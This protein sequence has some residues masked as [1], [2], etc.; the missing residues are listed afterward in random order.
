MSKTDTLNKKKKNNIV[1]KANKKDNKKDNKKKDLPQEAD[2]P[3]SKK[4]VNWVVLLLFALF[5]FISSVIVFGGIWVSSTY[6]QTTFEQMI[7][8]VIMPLD[9]VDMDLVSSAVEAIGMPTLIIVVASFAV[10]LPFVIISNRGQKRSRRVANIIKVICWILVLFLF[11]SGLLYANKKFGLFSFVKG[12]ISSSEFIEDNY[13]DPKDVE[14]VFPEEKKNLIYIFLEST[15]ATFMGKENGGAFDAD[16]IPEITKMALDNVNV[17]FSNT[18]K[19]GGAVSM[20]GAT[21]TMGAMFAQ[22]SGLPLKLPTDYN[23]KMSISDT[24]LSYTTCLGDILKEEGY[25][26]SI[27]MGS[28][29]KFGGRTNYY[30]IH[31]EQRIYDLKTAKTDGIIS[32]GYIQNYWGLYDKELYVYAK[33]VLSELSSSDEPFALT[34]LTV[35]THFSDGYPCLLC[36]EFKTDANGEYILNANGRYT[37]KRYFYNNDRYSNVYSCASKQIYE[38]VEWLKEQDFYEDTVIIIAGDHITM[39]ADYANGVSEDYIRTPVNIF[40]NSFAEATKTKNRLFSTMD[41]FPT[42]LAAMGVEIKGDKLGLGTN[43]FSGEK[44]L[45]E[46]YGLEY[47]ESEIAKKSSFYN[48]MLFAK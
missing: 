23:N 48:K 10:Y 12:S 14:L 26:Q 46:E 8:N 44:T 2:V 21:W 36:T 3:R 25:N 27:I 19:L 16:V 11:V 33:K 42:T 17:S 32:K 6:D 20:A 18:D 45:I 24:F 9:G 41:M 37:P 15:E 31:G 40:I 22:T 13:V 4:V 1:N 43:L 34:L 35:D 38:F 28:N 29:G 5:A 47:F 30:T 7:F 39:D